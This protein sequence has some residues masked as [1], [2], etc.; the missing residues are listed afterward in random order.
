MI[1]KERLTGTFVLEIGKTISHKQ[2]GYGLH[3]YVA[4]FPNT[5]NFHKQKSDEHINLEIHL[6]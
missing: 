1:F 3:F 2:L 5:M 6:D 4:L